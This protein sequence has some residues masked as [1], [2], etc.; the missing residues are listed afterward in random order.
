MNS[1]DPSNSEKLWFFE[2]G[3][4]H[5]PQDIGRVRGLGLI[6]SSEQLAAV[7]KY[8]SILTPCGPFPQSLTLCSANPSA[9]KLGSVY[10]CCHMFFFFLVR[11]ETFFQEGIAGQD[12]FRVPTSFQGHESFENTRKVMQSLLRKRTCNVI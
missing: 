6:S 9:W 1:D 7:C 11:L 8:Y 12:L 5:W 10:L 3:E 4:G 2:V